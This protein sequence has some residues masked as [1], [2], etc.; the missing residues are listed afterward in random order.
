MLTWDNIQ[1]NAV[2][3]SKRWQGIVSEKQ[4]DQGFIEALLRVFG[5]EDS[6]AVG[7]FQE[8]TRISD[9][10]KWIDYLWKGKIAIEMKSKGESLDNAFEQLRQYMY[11]IPE[12]DIPDLWLVSDFENIRL[13]RRSTNEVWNF[14]T[15]DL[16]KHISKFANIAG[17]TS[18]RIRDDQVEVN[19]KAA[20]KMAKLHDLLKGHGYD[21]HE[22]RV[23][24][25]RL[26]FCL[27]ADDTGIFPKDSLYRY[28]E[29]SKPD[30]S[31]LSERISKLFEV[32]NMP[33][34]VRIK[35]TL[36][37]D[38]FKQFRYINGSLFRENLPSAEFDTKM[39][40]TLLDCLNF[41]WNKISPA[42]FGA[43]FQGVMDKT[44]RREMG[45]HYTS[46][47]NIL[48]LINPLF[49]DGLWQEFDRVK[50]D[51]AALDRFHDKI[52]RLKFLDPA[53][54]C[55]NFLIITYRELRVLELEILKM[56]VTSQ[57]VLDIA[58]MLKVSVEQF[59]GIEYEDFP[60]QI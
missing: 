13:S 58:P 37:S 41:D 43:M 11:S 56:K 42:I 48:K 23:F 8:K 54:G 40:Q 22:L 24:L 5:V 45:A 20:E 26:L 59:Y 12:E 60:C 10:T 4:Q 30:G 18:E 28:I 7:T 53:C 39:R 44:Q 50:T 49:L 38:E 19:V 46:E 47:G 17:Y 9:S 35:R 33:P 27:F 55:G 1:A 3:F 25:V 21:G 57:L 16:R 14:K 52:A 15:K 31:D 32:L 6:R 2:A 29:T 51:P 34:E 36:L